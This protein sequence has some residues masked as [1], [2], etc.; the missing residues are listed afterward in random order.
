MEPTERRVH[1]LL[2]FL[3]LFDLTLVVWSFGFPQ[4]WFTVF[5]GT[6]Y[7]DPEGLLRRCGANWAAFLACQAIAFVRWKRDAVWLAVIAGVR[8]SDI[9]TDVTYTFVARDTTWFAKL[10]LPP[11]SL[12]NLL[13]GLFLLRA[14]RW[15]MASKV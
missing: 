1:G 7:D 13:F 14:Y 2:G 9:F 4:L 5:H 6:A 12:C 15:R 10:T 3:V 8:L 11:M